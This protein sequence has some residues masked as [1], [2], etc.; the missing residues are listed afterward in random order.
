MKLVSQE[1]TT[2]M[3]LWVTVEKVNGKSA[4]IVQ[5]RTGEI[6]FSGNSEES[7]RVLNALTEAQ[8]H[9]NSKE[10]ARM[11]SEANMTRVPAEV[12]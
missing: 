8:H 9:L 3:G 7:L 5:K 1:F 2:E 6:L 10:F 4:I 11:E 12:L